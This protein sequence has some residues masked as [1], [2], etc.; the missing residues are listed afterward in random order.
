MNEMP[1]ASAGALAV[2]RAWQ[3]GQVARNTMR[4]VTGLIGGMSI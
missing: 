3:H 1:S 4:V 2:T